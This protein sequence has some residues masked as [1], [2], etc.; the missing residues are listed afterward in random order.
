MKPAIGSVAAAVVVALTVACAPSVFVSGRGATPAPSSHSLIAAERLRRMPG[1]TGFDALQ[2]L[3]DYYGRANRRPA[4][5]FMLTIDGA[6]T[7]DVELLKTIPATDL[8]EIRIVSE[9]Q[10]L[11]SGGDVEIIVTT[12]GGRRVP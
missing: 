10:T 1:L 11:V 2:L 5:R 3:P 8:F 9:S 7:S 4:P 12:L 6:R